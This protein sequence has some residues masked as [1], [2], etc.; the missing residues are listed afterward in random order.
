MVTRRAFTTTLGALGSVG[1]AYWLVTDTPTVD[2][3]VDVGGV[4]NDSKEAAED[5]LSDEP[6]SRWSQEFDSGF[7]ERIHFDLKGGASVTLTD[8]HGLNALGVWHTSDDIRGRDPLTGYG[9]GFVGDL[10]RYGGTVSWGLVSDLNSHG[11]NYPSNKFQL[12]G[13][14]GPM[15]VWDIEGRVRF[16]IPEQLLD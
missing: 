12:V 14:S 11:T 2:V 13:L 16:Y 5:A 4:V 3:D 6:E 7:V 8:N 15:Y 1:A 10:P 9:H